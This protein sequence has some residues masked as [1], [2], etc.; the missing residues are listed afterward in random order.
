VVD[1]FEG[2]TIRQA[3]ALRLSIKHRQAALLARKNAE[4]KGAQAIAA[5][6]VARNEGV[7]MKRLAHAL[8]ISP[9]YIHKVTQKK[10]VL[11]LTADYSE[12]GMTSSADDPALE[13]VGPIQRKEHL[14]QL[15]PGEV[16]VPRGVFLPPD[17]DP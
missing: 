4:V 1:P 15:S 13:G 17:S 16:D 2:L 3:A 9:A 10:V 11:P 5:V 7:G 12:T 6:Q 14:D 8:G